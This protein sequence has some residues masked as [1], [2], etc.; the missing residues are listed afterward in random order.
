MNYREYKV[1]YALWCDDQKMLSFH[2][3]CL[4]TVV[5][6]GKLQAAFVSLEC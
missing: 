2:F 4:Q 5:T 6:A 1:F 3:T